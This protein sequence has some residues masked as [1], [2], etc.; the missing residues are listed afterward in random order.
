MKSRSVLR[1]TWIV[2]LSLAVS[3]TAFSHAQG[4]DIIIRGG[5]LFDG[6][7]DTVIPNPGISIRAGKIIDVSNA[8]DEAV[9]ESVIIELKDG[10]TILPGLFDLHAHYAMDLLGRGR[11]DETEAYPVLFLANGVT[12][13]YPC[14]EIDPHKMMDLRIEIDSGRR[15]GPR[16]HNSGPYFGRARYDWRADVSVEEIQREVDEWA[17]RGVRCFKA[18]GITAEHLAA[19]VERAHQHGIPVSGHLGS[20][21]EG[22]VNP[23]DA[24]RMGIDRVEHFLGGGALS[25]DRPAYNSL[26]NLEG[27]NTE[28]GEI[29]ALYV[30]HNV[31]FD[32]TLTAYGYF[33]KR[34]PEVYDYFTDE[35]QY[36]TAYTRELL[37]KREQRKPSEQFEKIYWVKRKTIKAFYDAGGGH[38]IT[39]GTDHPSWGEYL[40]PFCVHRE[41]HAMVLAGIPPADA[42][43]IATING[44]R[45]LD[46]AN[47]LGTVEP[48]KLADLVVIE[49]NPLEDIRHSRNVQV[50]I[51]AGRIYDPVELGNSVRGTIGPRGPEDVSDWIQPGK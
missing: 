45:A 25:P 49:G 34:D 10:E 41:L 22:T 8:R 5:L 32:A 29:M 19:L 27:T 21:Y 9:D 26:E 51:K 23:R 1:P 47:T 7:G 13:T 18:K 33:G 40:T 6:V 3:M 24:I 4:P 44:A 38:L 42:L 35:K 12:S 2:V 16:V 28:L 15:V 37:S 17:A 36:L 39:L 20:G 31:Y 48:G 14:G 50:V 46:V 43:K 11:V 30:T